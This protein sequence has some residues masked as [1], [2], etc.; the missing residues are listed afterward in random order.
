VFW[1]IRAQ[2]KAEK[3]RVWSSLNLNLDLSL[4]RALGP[5]ITETETFIE[6]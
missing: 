2:V 1:K 6:R 4:P 3:N 5:S